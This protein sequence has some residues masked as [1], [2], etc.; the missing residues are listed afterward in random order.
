MKR[1]QGKQPTKPNVQKAL[2]KRNLELKGNDKSALTIPIIY[3]KTFTWEDPNIIFY[4]INHRSFVVFRGDLDTE[5]YNRELYTNLILNIEKLPWYPKNRL[6]KSGEAER[7]ELKEALLAAS[8]KDRYVNVTIPKPA[9]PK[10]YRIL[11]SD[12]EELDSELGFEYS[13]DHNGIQCTFKFPKHNIQYYAMEGKICVQN[14]INSLRHYSSLITQQ[15]FSGALQGIEELRYNILR[16][17]ILMD[18]Y[19]SDA[20][21][22]IWDLPNVSCPGF[23]LWINSCERILDELLFITQETKNAL[24]S[25]EPK[26]IKFIGEQLDLFGYVWNKAIEKSLEYCE[27]AISTIDLEPDPKCIENSFHIIYN[28]EQSRQK[29][30]TSQSKFI[31][32]FASDESYFKNPYR[33][34]RLITASYHLNNIFQAS[35]RILGFSSFIAR[36]TLRIGMFKDK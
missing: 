16:Y 9:D 18:R 29:I 31:K 14:A 26:D 22:I 4:P 8:L 3:R 28:Y 17:E 19:F 25:L 32:L 5:E 2:L 7:I 20:L 27:L 12:M 1:P 15:K 6:T 13:T 35:E 33:A 11:K 21:N 30:D 23:F 24:K 36:S 34:Q 10:L